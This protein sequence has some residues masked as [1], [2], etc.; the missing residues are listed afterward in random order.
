MAHRGLGRK[1]NLIL[2]L[3]WSERLLRKSVPSGKCEPRRAGTRT[4]GFAQKPPFA[5]MMSNTKFS[6]LPGVHRMIRNEIRELLSQHPFEPFLVLTTS[7]ERYEVRYSELAALLR[8][9]IFIA[10][11]N[12]DRRVLIPF[13]HVAS[14]E[15]LNGRHRPT[16][17]KRKL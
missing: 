8:S 16:P 12:S 6:G 13:L 2:F 9:A 15:I 1:N 3:A 4:S 5:I 10:F 17:R 14:V 11:P 7:G